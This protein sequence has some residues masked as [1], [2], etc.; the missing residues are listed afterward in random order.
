MEAFKLGS[1]DNWKKEA[2]DLAQSYALELYCST[3]NSAK[4]LSDLTRII[5]I[6]NPADAEHLAQS[7]LQYIAN[8]WLADNKQDFEINEST[9]VYYKDGALQLAEK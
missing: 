7:A 9:L 1:L 4:V 2:M 5:K 6:K 3:H 8:E